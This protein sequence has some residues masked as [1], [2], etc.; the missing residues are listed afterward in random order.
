MGTQTGYPIW[1]K[2]CWASEEVLLDSVRRQTDISQ[3]AGMSHTAGG[4]ATAIQWITCVLQRWEDQ[5]CGQEG[6]ETAK[7]GIRCQGDLQGVLISI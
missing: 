7:A 6:G 4:E 3:R 1:T 5:A 2:G